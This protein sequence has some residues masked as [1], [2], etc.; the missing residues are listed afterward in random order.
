MNIKIISCIGPGGWDLYGRRF[1]E[2]FVKYWPTNIHLTMYYHDEAPK[3][4]IEAPNVTYVDLLQADTEI[5][6]FREATRNP[7]HNGQT[8]DGQYN[9]RMDAYKFCHKVFA[10]T[11]YTAKLME[12]KW[13]GWL[14]W[15]D[16]DIY[17]T[18]KVKSSWIT[19]FLPAGGDIVH[20]PRRPLPYSET[21]FLAFNLEGNKAPQLLADL[22]DV[23]VDMELFAWQEWHDGFVFSRL[24]YLHERNGLAGYSLTPPTYQGI[25]AFENSALAE[26]LVHLKGNRKQ[27]GNLPKGLQPLKIIPHDSMPK[28]HILQNAHESDKLFTRWL[29][30][31]LPHNRKAVV[32]S[33]GPSV[34]KHLEEI[35]KRAEEGDYIVCVKHSLPILM[36]AGIIPNACVILDPRPVAEESTHGVIRSTLFDNVDPK[37]T[38]F[39]ASMTDT[40]VTKRVMEKTSNIV[41]W[42]AWTQALAAAK[43]PH[44]H[45][46]VLGGTCSAWRTFGLLKV[47][48]FS[49]ITAYGFDFALDPTKTYDFSLLDDK[50]RPKYLQISVGEGDNRKPTISTGELTAGIQ[51]VPMILQQVVQS[52]M[53]VSLVGDEGASFLWNY[54][55]TKHNVK[56]EPTEFLD[57]EKEYLA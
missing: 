17:T 41:G 14:I 4:P 27:A 30:P 18:S 23:Y 9:F 20:L 45:P 13:K 15:L 21:S 33:A 7:P 25:D 26:K 49:R 55:V 11:N 57:F 34:H 38:F 3:D 24:L 29:K 2:T 31:C 48:G 12:E 39:I 53:D 5:A 6:K 50:G 43:P 8:P 1:V 51:D 16:A 32:V 54:L 36:K 10:I 47:L 28:E 37:T 46:I 35:R 52:G 19:K 40:S 44:G 42:F 56:I 22:R